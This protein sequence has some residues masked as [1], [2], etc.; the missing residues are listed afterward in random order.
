MVLCLVLM[1]ST[2]Q[3]YAY[4]D[5]IFKDLEGHQTS[6]QQLKGKWVF[7]NYW[8]SWCHPCLSEISVFNDFYHQYKK[9][10]AVFAVHYD[11]LPLSQLTTLVHKYQIDY[12]HLQ[13]NPAKALSLGRI[14]SVPTT[15]VF[16]PEGVLVQTLYGPQTLSSLKKAS[17]AKLKSRIVPF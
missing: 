3:V 11:K 10:V 4:A 13:N 8:A 16:N 17:V 1:G 9:H 2:Y 7:I 15:F 6:F 5:A 14:P 12:P